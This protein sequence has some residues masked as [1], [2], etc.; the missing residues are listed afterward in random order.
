ME[1]IAYTDINVKDLQVAGSKI[2]IEQLTQSGLNLKAFSLK[3]ITTHSLIIK[4]NCVNYRGNMCQ[5]R[6]SKAVTKV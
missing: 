5:M 4:K 6:N 2:K 3:T 1:Q